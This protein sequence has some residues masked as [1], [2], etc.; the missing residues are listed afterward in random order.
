MRHRVG[1]LRPDTQ[2]DD[3]PVKALTAY[4]QGR[5]EP[6]ILFILAQTSPE[7]T[8]P[9]SGDSLSSHTGASCG[10][11]DSRPTLH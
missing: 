8:P 2:A 9:G 6:N 7:F 4:L 5:S 11:C 10:S 3:N 1:G